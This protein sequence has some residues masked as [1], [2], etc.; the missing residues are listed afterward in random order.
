MSF[1]DTADIPASV[2]KNEP[3]LGL[4]T[5]LHSVPFQCTINVPYSTL[6]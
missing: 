2:L 5:M 4:D 1:V 3:G 6:A